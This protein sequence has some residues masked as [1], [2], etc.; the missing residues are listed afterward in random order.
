MTPLNEFMDLIIEWLNT[1]AA[2]QAK[3]LHHATR[4]LGKSSDKAPEKKILW[5]VSR[6]IKADIEWA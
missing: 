5:K 1:C 3:L 6:T 4:T 2:D